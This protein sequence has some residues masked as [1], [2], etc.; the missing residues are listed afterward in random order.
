[1]GKP[2][3]LD[4]ID[5]QIIA[6]TVESETV[7]K[8]L[9]GEDTVKKH[10]K[11]DVQ[12][13]VN[14][15]EIDKQ[16]RGNYKLIEGIAVLENKTLSF[17]G[18]LVIP[19]KVACGRLYQLKDHI[20][21]ETINIL[22]HLD[23][24]FPKFESIGL[25]TFQ[26]GIQNSLADFEDMGNRIIEK[27]RP[28]SPLCIGLYNGT[29]AKHCGMADDLTR[30][31]HE[32][33]L[34][35]SSVMV[36]RQ[37]ITTLA[38]IFSKINTRALWA[39]IAHSEGGLI[40]N[41][42]LTTNLYSLFLHDRGIFNFL[43]AHVIGLTYGAVAPI[44]DC[45]KLAINTYS[46]DDVVMYF[47]KDYLDKPLLPSSMNDEALMQMARDIHIRSYSLKNES[48]DFV[49]NQL[50]AKRDPQGL[51]ISKYPYNC[52]KNDYSLKIIERETTDENCAL[53]AKDHAFAG[54]TYQNALKN[55]LDTLRG[56]YKIYDC[57]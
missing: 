7:L 51:Y 38:K 52:T 11:S 34:N 1:M 31:S 18:K 17:N 2:G 26:N 4:D 3:T 46:I 24:L 49:F 57:R 10:L 27:L 53:V 22:D 44:P 14:A 41:E 5:A 23:L 42:V 28:E 45:V 13:V 54:A 36:I 8:R 20:K 29:N 37:M 50:K 25:F 33:H 30:F 16:Y 47:A 12:I 55:N 39:H 9:Y 48:I 35:T 6:S 19:C 15:K 43:K 40:A 56:R 32:W 21:G